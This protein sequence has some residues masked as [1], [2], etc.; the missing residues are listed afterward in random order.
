MT[1]V[2]KASIEPLS[3]QAPD[4]MGN[5]SYP[6]NWNNVGG[7]M[8]TEI[9]QAATRDVWLSHQ[10]ISTE[11]FDALSL[12]AGFI[13]SGVGFATM[14]LAYFRRSPDAEQDGPVETMEVDG[15]QF[16]RV[17]R[18]GHM[19]KAPD[20]NP[21]D[22][23][24]LVHVDKHHNLLFKAGRTIEI[25]SFADGR[26]YVPTVNQGTL[27]FMGSSATKT[28]QMPGGW[29]VRQVEL[30]TD[31]LVELPNPTR[32]AFFFNGESFQG[33]VTLDL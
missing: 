33:P 4:D 12:P 31:L 14:D 10:P 18:P 30:K 19:E 15:R 22:G 32:A 23:L 7:Q 2:N 28:R 5:Q 1:I 6:Y 20:G 9:M 26:D 3:E 29:T 16:M 11:Q 21:Y 13:K 27:G 25:M 24:I 17:A 8:V